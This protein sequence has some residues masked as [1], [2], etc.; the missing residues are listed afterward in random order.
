M[1]RWGQ[2]GLFL[3]VVWAGAFGISV[4]VAEW[5]SPDV[6]RLRAEEAPISRTVVPT[7]TGLPAEPKRAPLTPGTEVSWGRARLTVVGITTQLD[8][9][10]EPGQAR[11]EFVLEGP[12]PGGFSSY[13]KVVDQD[14]FLCESGIGAE[15]GTPLGPGEKTRVWI[16]YRC[17][18]GAKPATLSLDGAT[19]EFP[20][21]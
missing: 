4:V 21:P 7:P 9:P 12:H 6:G 20:Q 3:A 5:R 1:M 2:V 19:F 18:E 11:V 16:V 14:G 15:V 8:P 10:F 13:F 17:A